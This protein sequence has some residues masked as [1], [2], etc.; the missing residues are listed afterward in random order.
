M[1]KICRHFDPVRA[2]SKASGVSRFQIRKFVHEFTEVIY[3]GIL[4]P[5]LK[6]LQISIK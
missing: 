3:M 5:L 4:V 6:I 1:Y 2:V